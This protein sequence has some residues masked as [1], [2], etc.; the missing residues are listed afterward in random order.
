[1]TF[2][3]IVSIVEILGEEQY[4]R[5][6]KEKL[7][8]SAKP[9]TE[10]LHK[11]KLPRFSRPSVKPK[12]KHKGHKASLKNDCTLFSRLC[13]SCQSRDRN[14]D[15]FFTH[16]NQAAPPSLSLGGKLRLGTKADIL[17]CL[18]KETSKH[19]YCER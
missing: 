15:Q 9:I 10:P 18:E 7:V 6:V 13:I 16:E 4:H 2:C 11:N 8:E 3:E 5:F 1:M 14:L 17:H 12:A 19:P